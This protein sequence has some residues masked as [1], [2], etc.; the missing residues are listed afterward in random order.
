M[1]GGVGDGFAGAV[2]FLRTVHVL[3][4]G[5]GKGRGIEG[6]NDFA[7]IRTLGHDFGLSAGIGGENA[8]AAA[9]VFEDFI[10]GGEVPVAAVGDFQCK[11]EI[12]L[13]TERGEFGI[14]NRRVDGEAV[15]G[16]GEGLVE[17]VA[18]VAGISEQVEFPV[19]GDGFESGGQFFEATFRSDGLGEPVEL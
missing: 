8:Q 12:E 4:D 11:A 6:G 18:I 3:L 15:L 9:E 17:P 14:G 16:F 13:S 5:L 19:T 10:G 7:G 2:E 1:F